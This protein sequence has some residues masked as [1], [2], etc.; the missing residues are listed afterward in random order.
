[1]EESESGS[2]NLSGY[3]GLFIF[4]VAISMSIF[5][6]YTGF[7]GELAG[8]KQLSIHLTFAMILCF[9][10]FPAR[11][12]SP[13]NRIPLPDIILGIFAA[14]CAFYLF[15]NYNHVVTSVGDAETYDII[16][17]FT[18]I[19]LVLEATRRSISPILPLIC[20]IFLLY[21]YYGPYLPGELAHRGFRVKRIVDHIFMSGEGLWGVPLRVSA[22]FVFLFVLFGA[23]LD[24]I[25]AGSY[26]INL[27]F[28]VMGK[29]RGGPA[30]AAVVA[31]CA[32]GSISGSSIANTVTTGAMTIPLMKKVGFSSVT[33]GAV[34][35]AAST[36]GQLMPPIMGAA[37]FI[38]AEIIGVPY[39]EIVKA[40]FIPAVLSY[41]AIFSIVHLEA[42]KENIR[43]LTKEETPVFLKTFISGFHFLI[44]LGILIW[45]LL[46]VRWTPTT[47]ASWSILAG[48]FT[49][50]GNNYL[51]KVKFFPE[52]VREN[53]ESDDPAF[54]DYKA[55][56]DN[57]M[58][59]RTK[60]ELLDSLETG[61]RNMAGI[62][63]ACASCGIIV[64][65]VT[66]TG[67]GLKMAVL[68]TEA[69]G[70][71]LLLTLI[72]SV[73]ACIILGMGLPTTATYIIMAAMTAPAIMTISTDLSLGLPIVAIHLFV[74]YYGIVADDTPPVGLCAYAAAG[75]SGAD[76]VKTG[77]KS[78]R[79]DLAAFT[80]PF[81]FIYNTKLLMMN[82]T[83]L[84][85]CYMIPIC[86]IGMF[87]WSVFIQGFWI[88]KT[89]LLERIVFLG[90]AF[91]LVNPSGIT[92]MKME[93]NQHVINVFAIII[94]VVIYYWQK[95]R[96]M[97]S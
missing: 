80:L 9:A 50:L 25:G 74:F 59:G 82:T 84:E 40:A 4:A 69:A 34:E 29:Y 38:M 81:M 13:K 23:F 47:A 60:K 8:S 92:V 64:G 56:P 41:T 85:L 26:L 71:N 58:F 97:A 78:F 57:F 93:I 52:M 77:L 73:F 11:K 94:M 6:I 15:A 46:I 43:G 61:A 95:S 27:S 1:M 24:K 90:L 17:G 54:L 12:K 22:T 7:A 70:G 87:C 89:Y 51:R 30:K 53:L 62:A 96:K 49:A 44:P 42:V 14:G 66:L 45:L 83:I 5:Q 3:M 33:A 21:A 37:A 72:F 76:P 86:I 10:Y 75:I 16:I 19:V 36:N 35:V 18:L 48:A 67:L 32:M 88:V 79:L 39:I 28:A 20:I 2:R 63:V 91:L 65:V 55:D 31:S 68:I